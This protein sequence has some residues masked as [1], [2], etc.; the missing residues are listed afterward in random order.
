MF[1]VTTTAGQTALYRDYVRV[2]DI[3]EAH[4]RALNEIERPAGTA[5]TT[6]RME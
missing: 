2:L 3:A 4:F 6:S 1:L 5:S